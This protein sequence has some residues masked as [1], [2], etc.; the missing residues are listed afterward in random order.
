M[1]TLPRSPTAQASSKSA[2]SSYSRCA[3]MPQSPCHDILPHGFHNVE[4]N[5]IDSWGCQNTSVPKIPK[6]WLLLDD[7]GPGSY[8][9]G[10]QTMHDQNRATAVMATTRRS[11][12]WAMENPPWDV[13][14]R[15]IQTS[16]H[17]PGCSM[18]SPSCCFAT[19]H[20]SPCALGLSISRAVSKPIARRFSPVWL[21]ARL[22]EGGIHGLTSWW[23]MDDGHPQSSPILL[24][25]TTTI[26]YYIYNW[27]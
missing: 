11:K 4:L 17:R 25:R 20:P 27:I 21:K 3:R 15:S 16:W 9:W 14:K 6:A 5:G 2:S 23:Y 24:Q 12:T 18:A 1:W 7:R 13:P 8:H 10:L 22:G 19:N 26:T